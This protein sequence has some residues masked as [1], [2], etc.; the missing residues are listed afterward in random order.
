MNGWMDEAEIRLIKEWVV[1]QMSG[2][3]IRHIPDC[4][5]S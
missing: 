2:G 5:H 3:N 1:G 4:K